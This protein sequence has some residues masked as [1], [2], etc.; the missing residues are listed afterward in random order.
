MPPATRIVRRAPLLTRLKSYPLDTFLYL[1]EQI[2]LIEWDKLSETITLPLGLG[3]DF[4]LFLSR[5]FMR[6]L[7]ETENQKDEVFL[8]RSRLRKSVVASEVFQGRNSYSFRSWIIWMLSLL[9]IGILFLSFSNAYYVFTKRRTYTLFG[10]LP[11]DSKLPRVHSA[12]KVPMNFKDIEGT[13]DH[14]DIDTEKKRRKSSMFPNIWP[15]R[16]QSTPSSHS[17]DDINERE[18]WELQ[19]WTPPLFNLHLFSS[20]SPLHAVIAFNSSFSVVVRDIFM[21][22]FLTTQLY[23]LTHYFL[24]QVSDKSTIH[25]EMF[26]EYQK[27]VVRPRLDTIKMD[28]AIGDGSVEYFRTKPDRRFETHSILPSHTTLDSPPSLGTS[29][30]QSAAITASRQSG[31]GLPFKSSSRT[32]RSSTRLSSSFG[33]AQSTPS[34]YIS[35]KR[36][37]SIYTQSPLSKSGSENTTPK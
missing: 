23:F 37:S 6:A 25:G 11:T 8:D 33:S 14:E 35:R 34:E 13:V 10:R 20:F 26:D 2:E 5:V 16:Q 24:Q 32:S 18:V 1:N 21:C 9:S 28:A 4:V 31:F 15:L 12:R 7:E 29:P 3:F 27:K 22:V 30:F 36:R 19:I 17:T